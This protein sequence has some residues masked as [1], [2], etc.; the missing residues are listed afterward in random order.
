MNDMNPARGVAA[1][2]RVLWMLLIWTTVPTVLLLSASVLGIDIGSEVFPDSRFFAENWW[3][4]AVIMWFIAF[5]A[6]SIHVITN[7]SLRWYAR[8][9]LVVAIWFSFGVGLIVYCAISLIVRK[10]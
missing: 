3:L 6:G 2:P 4:I 1:G 7:C 5:V 8:T 9:F 10:T